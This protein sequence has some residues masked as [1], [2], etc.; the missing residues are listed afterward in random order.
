MLRI[1]GDQWELI[2]KHFPEEHCPDDRPVASRSRHRK[3]LEAVL[4]ILNTSA[5]LHMLL[6]VVPEL[7]NGAPPLSAVQGTEIDLSALLQ[8]CSP[9]DPGRSTAAPLRAAL[10]CRAVLCL[11][12][13][14]TSASGSLG[15]L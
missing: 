14:A 11:D 5:Q 6:Y 10:D 9:E 1:T 15:V 8:P 13:V 7:Q 4:R 2:R 12:S 3:V